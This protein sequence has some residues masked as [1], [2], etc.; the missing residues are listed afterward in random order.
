MAKIVTQFYP[1]FYESRVGK[2]V[3]LT[4]DNGEDYKKPTTFGEEALDSLNKAL[5][6]L[7]KEPDV[8]GFLLTGKP[9]IFAAGADLTQIPFINT[10]EQ[11]KAIGQYGA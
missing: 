10:F 4:M 2:I 8:K 5:D 11:G 7:Q 1:S 6:V 9:Y 3:I